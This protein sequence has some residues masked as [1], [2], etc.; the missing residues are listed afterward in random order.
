MEDVDSLGL[1]SNPGA[2]LPR[3]PSEIL[4]DFEAG[5]EPVEGQLVDRNPI[6]GS[7]CRAGS[8][9]GEVPDFHVYAPLR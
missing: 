8:S 7:M 4:C 5:A 3:H 2:R 1:D 9:V 6:N